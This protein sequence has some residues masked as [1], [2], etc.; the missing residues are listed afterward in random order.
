M[1]DGL[2]IRA[3][4]HTR[5][6]IAE[7]GRRLLTRYR[8]NEPTRKRVTTTDVLVHALDLAALDV[9]I[10]QPSTWGVSPEETER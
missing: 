10:E 8:K 3:D 2:Y 4:A 5:K 7:V 9:G 6:L 1:K